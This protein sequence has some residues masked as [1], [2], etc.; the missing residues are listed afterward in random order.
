VHYG[1]FP[2]NLAKGKTASSLFSH[3]LKKKI[4]ITF[5][6]HRPPSFIESPSGEFFFFFLG[7]QFLCVLDSHRLLV[8]AVALLGSGIIHLKH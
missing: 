1:C 6:P 7:L 3:Q 4:T 8:I 5:L 2:T